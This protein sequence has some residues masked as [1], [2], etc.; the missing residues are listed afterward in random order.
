MAGSFLRGAVRIQRPRQLPAASQDPARVGLA[1]PAQAADSEPN[2]NYYS[3]ILKLIPAEIVA[4]FMA[5]RDTA[6]S[7]DALTLWFACCLLACVLLRAQAS[8]SSAESARP[9][10]R[11]IQWISVGLSALAFVIWAH[12][13]SPTPPLP[14]LH[15][16]QWFAGALAMLL[17]AVAPAL[18]P[19]INSTA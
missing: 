3:A 18:I 17:G 14:M 13:V 12:A 15:L 1:G 6:Q 16:A 9:W 4:A 10:F 8:R 5:A 7:H 19:A 2:D 11:D